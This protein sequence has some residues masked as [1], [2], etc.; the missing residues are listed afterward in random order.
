MYRASWAAN[1]CGEA[2]GGCLALGGEKRGKGREERRERCPAIS[3]AL[4]VVENGEHSATCYGFTTDTATGHPLIP[5]RPVAEPSFSA[6]THFLKA[7][8]SQP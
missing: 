7:H 5:A 6:N 2:C 3:A 8:S 4:C 1:R